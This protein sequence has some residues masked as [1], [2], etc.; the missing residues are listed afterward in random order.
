MSL[1]KLP[2]PASYAPIYQPFYTADQML[3]FQAATVEACAAVC[4]EMAAYER[5]DKCAI[6]IRDML[7]E[8]TE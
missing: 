3:A 4:N 2:E 7:K 8:K 5:A 6:A 1:P